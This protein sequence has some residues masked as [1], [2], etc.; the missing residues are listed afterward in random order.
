[1]GSDGQPFEQ[2]FKVKKVSCGS[3][4]TLHAKKH[5]WQ[6]LMTDMQSVIILNKY[7]F[8]NPK[9]YPKSGKLH[10]NQ[11]SNKREEKKSIANNTRCL[12]KRPLVPLILVLKVGFLFRHPVHF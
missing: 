2:A 9:F 10:Q 6:N 1:M 12:K 4:K 8:F 7:N 5:P 3:F 11:T